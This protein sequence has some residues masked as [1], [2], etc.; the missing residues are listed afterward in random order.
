MTPA[1]VCFDWD[2]KEIAKNAYA[3]LKH[4]NLRVMTESALINGEFKAIALIK[5]GTGSSR[6]TAA[7]C[8]KFSGIN[9]FRESFAPIHQLNNINLGQ[10]MAGH[11]TLK[12]LQN[13]ETIPLSEFTSKYVQLQ[14]VTQRAVFSHSLKN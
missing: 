3:G 6:E 5:T 4:N 8:E 7:Q 13:G 2:P 9:L 11:E 10:L 12:R 14:L 1:W